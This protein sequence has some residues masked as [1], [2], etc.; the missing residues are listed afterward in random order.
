[1]QSMMPELGLET[2]LKLSK[3]TVLGKASK[4]RLTIRH[5]CSQQ[6]GVSAYS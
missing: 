5:L 1:M 3:L 4:A 6:E 2:A